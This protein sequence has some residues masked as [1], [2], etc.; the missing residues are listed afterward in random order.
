[1]TSAQNQAGMRIRTT[2]LLALGLGLSLAAPAL[3]DQT[4][5]VTN[6]TDQTVVLNEFSNAC[7][8]D[9]G[10]N[11]TIGQGTDF[12]Q[13]FLKSGSST[14][15]TCTRGNTNLGDLSAVYMNQTACTY[16]W[17]GTHLVIDFT[18]Q[19]QCK[20]SQSGGQ[21]VLTVSTS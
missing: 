18:P 12:S 7:T 17:N 6:S 9:V 14:V 2:S 16:H 3:A 20:I 11:S 21:D 5:T 13:A 19:A 1:V 10:W 15:F 4:F 8:P